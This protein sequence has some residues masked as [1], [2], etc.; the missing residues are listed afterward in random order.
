MELT[1]KNIG[2]VSHAKIALNGITVIAGPNN[3]AKSTV[4]K[5][6]Y[7]VFNSFYNLDEQIHREKVE[8]ISRVLTKNLELSSGNRRMIIESGLLSDLLLENHEKFL[9]NKALLKEE[10]LMVLH[11]TFLYDKA[12][13]E[14]IDMFIEEAVKILTLPQ[15][16][17]IAEIISKKMNSEFNYQVNNIYVPEEVAE[18]SLVI[19]G[20]VVT[21]NLQNNKVIRVH[22]SHSL[23]TEVIYLDDPYILDNV[24]RFPRYFNMDRSGHHKE[25]L[26]LKLLDV[27]DRQLNI[28]DNLL[29]EDQIEV[30]ETEI[31]K[32]NDGS[33]VETKGQYG[34][35]AKNQDALLNL[36]NISTG[37]KTFVIIKTLL[38]NGSLE[39]NGTLILDEPEIHLHPEWQ[40]ALAEIIVLIQKEFGMHILLNTHSPYFLRAIEVYSAKHKI[41][42]KCKYYL[43]VNEEQTSTLKDVTNQIDEIYKKLANPLEDLMSEEE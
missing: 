22:N 24:R 29:M 35:Q 19:Q 20:K 5:V 6:L 13:L 36:K 27:G 40:L 3:S 25:H 15:E 18:V 34:Y 41:A 38:T 17:I 7:S 43:S 30:I 23:N 42:D 16:R 1:I 14:K 28:I 9:E 33:L 31:N 8:S 39:E 4:G 37:L 21:I 10:L 11:E 12:N 26:Q 2:K 32:I